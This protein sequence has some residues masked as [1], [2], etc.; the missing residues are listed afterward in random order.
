MELPQSP[1]DGYKY[2][3]KS[4]ILWMLHLYFVRLLRFGTFRPPFDKNIFIDMFFHTFQFILVLQSNNSTKSRR[5]GGLFSNPQ[6]VMA[7][8]GYKYEFKKKTP[9][10]R[11]EPRK[12]LFSHIVFFLF[13]WCHVHHE[14]TPTCEKRCKMIQNVCI[15]TELLS[16]KKSTSQA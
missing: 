10:F 2:E 15:S 13:L 9:L 3:L 7:L 5:Y 14:T 16:S 8:R 1:G 12:G 6:V 11:V 4:A